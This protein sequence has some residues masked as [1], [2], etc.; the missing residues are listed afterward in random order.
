MA[1]STALM[2]PSRSSRSSM[3]RQM[4]VATQSGRDATATGGWLTAGMPTPLG[5][6]L[7]TGCLCHLPLPQ[8]MEESEMEQ[9]PHEY[10]PSQVGHG[11]AQCKWCFGTNRENAIIAPNH[12]SARAERD[13]AM[14]PTPEPVAQR[15]EPAEPIGKRCPAC[16][17][18][19]NGCAQ[20]SGSGR[21]FQ[22][23]AHADLVERLTGRARFCRDRGEIKTPELLE[24]AAA[25]LTRLRAEVDRLR[26]D[27]PTD[28]C[29]IADMMAKHVENWPPLQTMAG[30]IKAI[31]KTLTASR[32]EVVALR[33]EIARK[34]EALRWYADTF[35]EEGPY[36]EVCGRISDEDCAGCKARA[37]LKEPNQ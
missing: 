8:I 4:P 27:P 21:E 22:P 29:D 25:E 30:S 15:I 34:D 19:G 37:A 3:A 2:T 35:C 7:P 33:A 6:A 9:V 16:D 10:G 36:S 13:P 23:V 24:G 18:E 5:A 1:R 26:G 11:E 32:D 20:C 14:T 31:D 12:C 28:V 17:G